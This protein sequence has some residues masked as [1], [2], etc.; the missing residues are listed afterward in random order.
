MIPMTCGYRL[1]ILVCL[2]AVAMAGCVPGNSSNAYN[3]DQAGRSLSVYSGTLLRVDRVSIEGTRSGVGAAGGGVAGGVVGNTV[4]GG[5]A[6]ALA[7]VAGA[8]AGAAVGAAAEEGITRKDAV[9]L[10]VEMDSGELIVVVQEADH[11]F[12]VGDR[13]RIIKDGSGKTKVRQ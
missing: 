13:V 7:T 8:I 11:V 3:R 10:E 4:G 1:V 9:E 2:I 5:T 6:R 12:N